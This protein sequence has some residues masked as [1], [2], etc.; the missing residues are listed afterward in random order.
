[1]ASGPELGLAQTRNRHFQIAI[2]TSHK[3]I[4]QIRKQVYGLLCVDNVRTVDWAIKDLMGKENE[5]LFDT[6]SEL[7]EENRKRIDDMFERNLQ[8]IS[9]EMRPKSHREMEQLSYQSVYGKLWANRPA[10]TITTGFYTPGRGRFIHPH[11]KRTITAHE[12]ARIQGFPDSFEFMLANGTLP[13]RATLSKTIGD[14]V[15]PVFGFAAILCAMAAF[16]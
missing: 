4:E 3:N 12:A 15:P 2:K 8:E 13:N 10:G 9:K 16:D 7:S 14:A 11:C 1:M 6:P 5:T